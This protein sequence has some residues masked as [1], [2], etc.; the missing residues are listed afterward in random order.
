MKIMMH[1]TKNTY[2]TILASCLLAT[3]SLA[4][5][6]LDKTNHART[7]S[8]HNH[9][10]DTPSVVFAPYAH[11]R[12]VVGDTDLEDSGLAHGAHDPIYNGFSV[13]AL[14]LGADLRYGD[15]IGGFTEGIVSWNDEDHWDAEIEELYAEFT[16]LPGGFTIKAGQFLTSAGS[17]NTIHNHGWKFVDAD[18]GSVRFLG[19][20]G[21]ITE[22]VEL[23]WMV[24]TQWDDRLTL[25]FGNALEHDHEEEEEHEGDDD[26]GEEAEEALWDSNIFAAR[27]ETRFWSSDKSLYI[28]GASYLQG[29]NFMNESAQLYGLDLA[30]TWLQNED[31]GKKLDWR[32]E[33][34][35]R[36]VDT[37]EGSFE[38]LAFTSAAHY[39]LNHAWEVGL[40]YDYLEGVEDPELPQR[41]RLSPSLCHYFPLDG[42]VEAFLRLQY[43]YDDSEERGDDHS[44][45]LQF[46]FGWGAGCD[47]HAH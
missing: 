43:N 9:G 8:C 10:H 3:L 35:M 47:T 11:L 37:G 36:E 6:T 45:W 18:L 39:Q 15:H 24:P 25:S 41:H 17:Q 22:G 5:T 34:M 40:R 2:S 13:P 7:Q 33:L 32:N 1:P 14:S 42:G 12:A 30:Y 46:G 44:I 21:L 29:K 4:D 28:V 23:T 31:A 20:D 19:D 26:H 16:N 38:E 27:Y